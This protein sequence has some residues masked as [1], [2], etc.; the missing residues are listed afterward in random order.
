MTFY[1]ANIS[2]S[3]GMGTRQKNPKGKNYEKYT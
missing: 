3:T 2:Q 1:T